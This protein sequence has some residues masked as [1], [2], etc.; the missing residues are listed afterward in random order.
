MIRLGQRLAQVAICH[1]GH[2]GAQLGGFGTW[3]IDRTR[4]RFVWSPGA[5]RLFGRD[6]DAGEP[7]LRS[8]VPTPPPKASR[9]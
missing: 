9:L 1:T 6:P 3:V 8:S 2:C 7:G 5:F 4:N